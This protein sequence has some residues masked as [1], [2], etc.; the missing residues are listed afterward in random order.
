MHIKALCFCG[1]VPFV[2]SRIAAPDAAGFYNLGRYNLEE[3]FNISSVL[4]G[5]LALALKGLLF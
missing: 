1:L 5:P 3:V 4:Q 2:F